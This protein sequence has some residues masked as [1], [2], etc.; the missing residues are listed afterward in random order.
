MKAGATA[1]CT[2]ILTNGTDNCTLTPRQLARGSYQITATYNGDT[3]YAKSTSPPQ[4]L[5]VTRR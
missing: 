2:I 3:T 5:T 1:V 4:T